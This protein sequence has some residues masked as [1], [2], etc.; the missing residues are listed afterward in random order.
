M[1]RV[2]A[3][4]ALMAINVLVFGVMALHQG[5][6][7]FNRT[8]DFF[9]M[10]ETGANFNPF[11]VRG[12][13]WR[14]FASMFLHWGILHLAVNMYA[15]YGVGRLLEG[16]LGP[17]R[18]TLFYFITGLA[19]GISS[20]YF[21]VYVVSAG[22]S[23]AIFG[24]YGYMIMQQVLAN[25]SN[26]RALR[27]I[28]FNFIVF[29]VVNYAISRQV[30]VDNAGHIGGFLA[31]IILCLLNFSGLFIAIWQQAA[32]LLLLPF[33]LVFVPKHQL[34]YYEA[35]NLVAF[36][37]NRLQSVNNQLLTDDQ[38]ADSLRNG[39]A[40][41][42]DSALRRLEALERI[43]EKVAP[44]TSVLR[45]YASLRKEQVAYQLRGIEKETF[46]YMDTVEMIVAKLDSLPPL[47]FQLSYDMDPR[48]ADPEE[49]NSGPGRAM[50]DFVTAYYDSTWRELPG[51]LGARFYRIGR[52]D[53]LDRWQG[54]VQ[55][56]YI[57]GTIQMKG[58]YVDNM[59]DGVFR[60]YTR[61]GKYESLGRY[62]KERP[63]GKWENYHANGLLESEV[64]YGNGSFTRTVFDSLGNQQVKDG[65]G[66]VTTLYSNGAIKEEGEY[67]DGR[68]QG[69]WLGYYPSGKGH[70][71]E[72]YR[73]GLLVR[74][75][76]LDEKGERYVYDQLS[77]FPFPEMGMPAYRQY[78][79][80]NLKRHQDA[81]SHTGTVELS[82][83]VQADG[84]IQDFVVMESLCP[85]CDQEAI[86]LVRDGPAWRPGVLRGHI[87]IPSNGRVEVVF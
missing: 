45:R 70:F 67:I 27:G 50:G 35:Y 66:R 37:D 49:S 24:L 87:K 16:F 83:L 85:L 78:L 60:Y 26:K 10:L 44:D 73:D 63:V 77:V 5:D 20:V 11:V 33:A 59:H 53:S 75:V 48:F 79:A 69:T 23:G 64:Y 1:K 58:A 46:V 41:H 8:A 42:F 43:P 2:R 54:R 61:D 52:R 29:A 62:Q 38:R 13:Y 36:A 55:D 86:R 32:L 12:E 19:A 40:P 17:L 4:L 81:R 51:I 21:N 25:F 15:L 22:A 3:T 57:N 71:Q 74:G 34:Q 9:Y 47:T 6:I 31:G 82:F 18:L 7:W 72:L 84:H 80:S 39:V 28:A 30:N 68:K 76:A 65:N 56:Y 14:L